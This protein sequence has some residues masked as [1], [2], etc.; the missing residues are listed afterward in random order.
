MAQ[1]IFLTVRE[2]V[3]GRDVLLV[4]PDRVDGQVA[5]RQLAVSLP[6]RR[7]PPVLVQLSEQYGG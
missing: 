7:Q 4:K 2:M 3:H 6:V 1:Q 5:E